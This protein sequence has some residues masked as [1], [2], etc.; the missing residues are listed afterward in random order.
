[1]LGQ[2]AKSKEGHGKCWR[3]AKGLDGYIQRAGK[4]LPEL[5]IEGRT[6]VRSQGRSG[7]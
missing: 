6:G 2:E 3:G 5:G 4:A 1:M 7:S